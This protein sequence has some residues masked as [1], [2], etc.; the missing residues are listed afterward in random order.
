MPP[1]QVLEF[2]VAEIGQRVDIKELTEKLYDEIVSKVDESDVV[3]VQVVPQRW[4]RKVRVVC[5]HQA[6]KDCLMIQGLDLYG[7]HIE[8]HEP[9]NGITKV[10]IQDAP[11]EMPNDI[12]KSWVEQYGV[13]SEFRNEHAMYQNRRLNWRT[14]VRHAYVIQLKESIPPSAKLSFDGGEVTITAWHYGQTHMKCR[15]CKEIVP[16]DAHTC[17]RAPS[18]KCFN[19]GSTEHMRWECTQ[20]KCCYKCG[21]KTHIARECQGQVEE[22]VT[23]DEVPASGS[24]SDMGNEPALHSTPKDAEPMKEDMSYGTG[25]GS[26]TID[27]T[28]ETITA[29]V[30]LI[31]SSNCRELNIHG[32][33][34]LQINVKPLIQ[35]GLLIQEAAEKLDE[36]SAEE[37]EQMDTVLVHVGSCN[38]PANGVDELER[39]YIHF[40][41]L[42]STV[43]N[44]CPNASMV[45]SGVIPRRGRQNANINSQI[46]DFNKK[47]QNLQ[48]DND[49][50]HFLDNFGFFIGDDG[51]VDKD[52]FKPADRAGIH[53]NIDGQ[54]RLSGVFSDAIKEEY[55]KR[56]LE[57]Q[58]LQ[59]NEVTIL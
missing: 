57:A 23:A 56:K 11:I 36:C 50:I 29:N 46:K 12:I 45:V 33:D 24:V 16:K 37:K 42:L 30:L 26:V 22:I 14:G 35:G 55:F 54:K 48:W 8:L 2:Q 4:P 28:Q 10:V 43:S 32:D 31:G 39:H 51:E 3:G 19:C 17:P 13:V 53:L 47:L 5:A 49:K 15:W 1:G 34:E 44:A 52:L 20:G 59:V 21:S 9:G 25:D 58:L 27:R 41:E 40:V 18:K 7:R 38:F 6:A